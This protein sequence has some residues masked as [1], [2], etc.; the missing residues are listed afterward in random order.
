[1]SQLHYNTNEKKYQ[2]LSLKER[3]FLEIHLQKKDMSVSLIATIL[4][5]HRSTLYREIK[6]GLTELRRKL[7]YL[8]YKSVN[9]KYTTRIVYLSDVAQY[10]AKQRQ[11]C[12]AGK[13]KILKD[14]D[15]MRYI[16]NCLL[17]YKYSPSAII[18]GLKAHNLSFSYVPCPKSVYNYIE[19]GIMK[20]KNMDLPL[21]CRIK[22]KKSRKR[23]NKRILGRSIEDRPPEVDER[24]EFGHFEADS[25][26]GKDGNSSVLTLTERKTRPGVIL[27]VNN[28][29]ANETI[30]VLSEYIKTLPPGTVNSITFDNGTEFSGC[31]KLEELGCKIYF[32]HPY[33]AWERGSNENFNGLVRRFIPKGKD[34]T[35]YTQQDLNRIANIIN[36]MPRKV[37]NYRTAAEA[38]AQELIG[39]AS[40]PL[41]KND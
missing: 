20:A 29:T 4:G 32:A 14:L 38:W 16:D 10:Y 26:V 7:N 9:I 18:G 25:I 31:A 1:M 6:K 13:Y 33:S 2:H 5:R 30:R 21:K 15:L 19:R 40:L 17:E 41:V 36:A 11:G 24:N 12:R 3:E 23:K 35:K 22:V 34:M 37:L 28:K 27:K 39:L 8:S